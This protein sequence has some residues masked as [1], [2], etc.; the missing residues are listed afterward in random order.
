MYWRPPDGRQILYRS[1]DP[2]V[3]GLALVSID[4]LSVTRVPTSDSDPRSLRPLG[5]TPDGRRVL[6]QDDGAPPFRTVVVD[7]DSGAQIH[8]DVAFGHVSNDGT[9]VAGVKLNGDIGGPLCVVAITGGTCTVVGE[10]VS[11]EGPHGASVSW[12]PDDRWIVLLSRSLWLVDTTG[13]TP[14]RVIA[15]TGTGSW[16]RIAP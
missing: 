4:D 15:G 1:G 9:R 10:T 11:V 16:Q 14:P 8:L 12:S 2:D 6:Y 7:V 3:D 13:T 5:W